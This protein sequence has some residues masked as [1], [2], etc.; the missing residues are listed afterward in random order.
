[1]PP[2]KTPE[3]PEPQSKL[4]YALKNIISR[5]SDKVVRR[6][7]E[8]EETRPKSIPTGSLSLDIATGIGGIPRG[9]VTE[10][11]GPESSGKTTLALSALVEVQRQ[12]GTAVFVDMDHVFSLTYAQEL[13][14]DL[15]KLL[16]V[17]PKMGEDAFDIMET[18][19]RSGEVDIVVL[20][21]IAAVTPRIL[22][23]GDMGNPV[24][25]HIP[26]LMDQAM[27]KL[28]APIAETNTCVIFT[29]Q[30]RIKY[31]VMFGNP[32]TTTGGL[33]LKHWASLRLDMRRIQSIKVGADI[34]GNR[35]R[36]RVVKNRLASPFRSA[37]FDIIYGQGISKISEFL[38]LAVEREIVSKRG[39]Y[40]SYGET[41]IGKQGRMNAVEFLGENEKI[42][43]E[44]E[45]KLRQEIDKITG[46]SKAK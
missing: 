30:L 19:I 11:Y 16:L 34:L 8:I 22:L 12:G 31:G 25:D 27:R 37:E 18:L 6:A 3:N 23:E 36:V 29:N 26:K 5:Y 44:I 33:P 45:E 10:I 9:H 42:A 32:E 13:G 28:S 7:S 15:D 2:E 40:Y 4:D 43:V 46:K 39:A 14:A 38:D 21:S 1:M 24:M 17:Q 20:D 35:T 41:S